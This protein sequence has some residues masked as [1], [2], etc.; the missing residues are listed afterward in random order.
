MHP[1]VEVLY[2]ETLNIDCMLLA[3]AGCEQA[4]AWWVKPDGTIVRKQTLHQ[5]PP[6]SPGIYSCF[7]H[8]QNGA[9]RYDAVLD[10][11]GKVLIV[12]M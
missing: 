11:K 10:I 9:D 5:E 1:I 8:H 12:P 4:N 7:A 3:I 6:H 2:N